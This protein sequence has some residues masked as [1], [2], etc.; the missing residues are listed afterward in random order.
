MS[1]IIMQ[2]FSKEAL[3]AIVNK[4]QLAI[5]IPMLPQSGS[6]SRNIYIADE[7]GTT[8]TFTQTFL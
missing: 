6:N 3:L 8:N 5:L 1:E 4:S 2:V 7:G